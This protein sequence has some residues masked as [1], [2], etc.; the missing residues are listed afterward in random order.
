MYI[1]YRAIF[2]ILAFLSPIPV[3]AFLRN[4][5]LKLKTK[6]NLK[7][8]EK[9]HKKVVKSLRKKVKS[10]QKLNVAFYIYDET[11]W[12]CQS[13]YDLMEQS[14][15]FVPYIYVSINCAFPSSFDYQTKENAK[16]TYEFF[17]KKGLRVKYAY[18]IEKDDYISFE[19]MEPRPDIVYY[20]HP[21][22]VYKTQGPVMCSKYALTYYS[23]Y[24]ISASMGGQEYYLRFY[25]Y[26]ETQYVLNNI[27]KDYF[28]ENMENKGK[29][30]KV[31]GHPTL[32]YF[33]F[34]SKKD[35]ENTNSII[36]APHFSVDETTLLKWGTFL[37]M[38]DFILDYAKQHSEFNWIFKPHPAL[39]S[40]LKNK[41]HW[42]DERIEKYW[43]DW[44]KIGLVYETGDYLDLFMQSKAM[45]TDCGSFKTEYFMTQK[46]QIYL[47]SKNPVPNNP[48]VEKINQTSYKAEN[49]EELSEIFK[50]LL[51]NN[52]D[53]KMQERLDLYKE[54]GYEN[55]YTALNI[56]NDMKDTLRIR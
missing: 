11:K 55:N 16:K 40:Y 24:S 38:G 21:W 4:L 51:E 50:E 42:N 5:G 27:I 15:Y 48:S 35:F 39:K 6:Q 54:F 43:N 13:V 12:K 56:I 37:E 23:P 44:S 1:K 22:N 7:Y 36:Y 30:L 49:I 17:K 33:Y 29:N 53:Y 28:S 14:E 31:A 32:D 45:I 47:K 46:P 34:N 19:D 3:R 41:H 20:C 9:N 25:L 52:N 8:I 26:V 2:N 18:D 10:G